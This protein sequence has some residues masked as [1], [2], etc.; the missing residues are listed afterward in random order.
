MNFW[1][2][3]LGHK[4]YVFTPGLQ[5]MRRCKRCGKKQ[6]WK[7]KEP[8]IPYPKEDGVH[9]WTGLGYWKDIN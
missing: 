8:T 6:K 9:R 2:W 5:S 3:L 7:F 4:W 1:C